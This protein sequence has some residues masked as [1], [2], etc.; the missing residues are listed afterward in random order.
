MFTPPFY[1]EIIGFYTSIGGFLHHLFYKISKIWC[2]KAT[3]LVRKTF[4]VI[5][6]KHFGVK[7][8]L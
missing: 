8:L 2:K 4:G 7:K 6:S 5:K 1:H 3:L